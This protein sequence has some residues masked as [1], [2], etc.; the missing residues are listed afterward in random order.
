LAQ[1]ATTIVQDN[2]DVGVS[3]SEKSRTKSVNSALAFSKGMSKELK[4][5]YSTLED[6]VRER[7]VELEN[8]GECQPDDLYCAG[9]G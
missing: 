5:I 2:W 3:S 9:P 6:R 8:G 7:T 4:T 1:I